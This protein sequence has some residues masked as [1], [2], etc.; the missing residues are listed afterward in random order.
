MDGIANRLCLEELLSLPIHYE[1]ARD[2]V[3]EETGGT[4]QEKIK[5]FFS[6]RK[7]EV[8]YES[9]ENFIQCRVY[10]IFTLI[11]LL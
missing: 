7:L 5:R 6:H 4:S 3:G 11:Y 10:V 8:L 1:C 2:L 9:H